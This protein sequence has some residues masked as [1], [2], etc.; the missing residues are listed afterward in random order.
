V[1]VFWFTLY[2][3]LPKYPPRLELPLAITAILFLVALVLLYR[4]RAG[5][6]P[7]IA[8]FGFVVSAAGLALWIVG[9]I[10]N[11]LDLKVT[12]QESVWGRLALELIKGPQA[13]WGLFSVGLM[14]IGVAAIRGGLPLPLRFL[15][16]LG[17]LF[18]LGLPLKYF[19]GD[20]AGGL[21]V[22]AA[23]GAGW[24]AIGAL[25]LFKIREEPGG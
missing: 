3:S 20:R 17:G 24:L 22:L 4:M 19:L 15:L 14:P 1:T 18:I 6:W 11:E 10:V 23:F 9:G 12:D 5:M 2:R 25:F 16:P 21:T 13:G 8:Q 7:G